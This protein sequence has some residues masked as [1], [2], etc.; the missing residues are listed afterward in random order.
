MLFCR[1]V[2]FWFP[3]DTWKIK[4][5]WLPKINLLN[6]KFMSQEVKMRFWL[7]IS[8]RQCNKQV[9]TTMGTNLTCNKQVKTTMETNFSNLKKT[10][11]H[12]SLGQNG[13][14]KVQKRFLS[15]HQIYLLQS[16]FI[17]LQSLSSPLIPCQVTWG[18]LYS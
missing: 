16:L 6:M 5:K 12:E 15:S 4:I 1:F 9:K 8:P 10:K 2:C 18:I 13:K 11:Y 3:S 17:Y 7:F 14:K